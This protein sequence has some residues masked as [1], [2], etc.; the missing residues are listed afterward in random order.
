MGVAITDDIDEEDGEGGIKDDLEE[1]VD[2]DEDGAVF[3]VAAGEVGP[4]ED[5][6]IFVSQ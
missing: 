6:L 1:G 2:R 3:A 4:D 5:L